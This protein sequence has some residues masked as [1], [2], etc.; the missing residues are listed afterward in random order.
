LQGS[1]NI[2]EGQAFTPEEM[3]QWQ[4]YVRDEVSANKNIIYF[5]EI[6]G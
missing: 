3:T 4:K 2:P 6:W 1:Y 5:W